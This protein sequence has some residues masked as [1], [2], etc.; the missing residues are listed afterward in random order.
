MVLCYLLVIG[1]EGVK[2]GMVNETSKVDP[3]DAVLY[4]SHRGVLVRYG[5]YALGT[6]CKVVMQHMYIVKHELR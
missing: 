6:R 1:S 4:F 2:C 5:G 3:S